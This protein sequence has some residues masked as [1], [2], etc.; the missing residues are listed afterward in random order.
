MRLNR[1]Y[2][3]LLMMSI[4]IGP[5][6]ASAATTFRMDMDA[7]TPGLQTDIWLLPGQSFTSNIEVVMDDSN[8]SLATFGYSLWWD[9]TELNT[10]EAGDITTYALDTD[11]ADFGY[12]SI[13]S[14]YIYNFAQGN[15]ADPPNGYSEGALTSV[16]ASI[17]W[18]AWNP[19]TNGSSDNTLGF[20]SGL[21]TAYNKDNNSFTPT[22]EGGRVNLVPEPISSILFVIGG[23]AL[24]FRRLQKKRK[25]VM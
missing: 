22:F 25:N 12:G 14:P 9:T 5:S 18:T 17:V 8:D 4:I 10:P 20:Y 2:L 16:V 3:L 6:L 15:I 1:F 23:V 19:V 7:N 24:G 21:D 13:S 11:W